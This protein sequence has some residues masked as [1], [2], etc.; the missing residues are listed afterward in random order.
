VATGAPSY[1]L[2]LDEAFSFSTKSG[3]TLERVLS[4]SRKYGLQLTMAC[5]VMGQIPTELRS[6][7]QQTTFVSFRLGSS[8]ASFGAER[9][10]SLDPSKIKVSPQGTPSWMSAHEQREEWA[11]TLS[12]LPER[13]AVIRL[14][15]ET[16]RFTTLAIPQTTTCSPSKLE[17]IKAEYAKRYLRP[18]TTIQRPSQPALPA[19]QMPADDRSGQK[20]DP[21]VARPRLQLPGR[22][23]RRVQRIVPLSEEDGEE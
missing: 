17:G 7:L 3:Q 21:H 12:T 18:P 8:D 4:Q 23:G 14:G 16:V 13:Q 5:Q 2:I 22:G 10:V 11:Y 15:D 9:V 20:A 19:A 1:H 6:A